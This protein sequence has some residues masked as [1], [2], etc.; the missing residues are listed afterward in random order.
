M[1]PIVSRFAA[2]GA[3]LFFGCICPVEQPSINADTDKPV[4]TW[5][6]GAAARLCVTDIGV[7]CPP[8]INDTM[9][10]G[11]KAYWF[12][13]ARGAACFPDGI[14]QPVHYGE[15]DPARCLFDETDK[16]GG[17]LGGSPLQRGKRYRL[18]LAG[19]GGAPV[20]R[21]FVV[22]ALESPQ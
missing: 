11:T 15:A 3:V 20:Y 1:S 14:E 10:S 21:E 17:Q 5:N 16:N 7:D 6:S 9:P 19:F 18:G 2:A 12:V 4:F 13:S 22:G 8:G